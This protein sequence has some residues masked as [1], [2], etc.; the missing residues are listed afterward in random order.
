M[1]FF[2]RS[3]LPDAH[4]WKLTVMQPVCLRKNKLMSLFIAQGDCFLLDAHLLV[5]ALEDFWA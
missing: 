5:S 4:W 2:Q 3:R 1:H